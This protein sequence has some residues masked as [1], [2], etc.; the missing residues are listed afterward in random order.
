MEETNYLPGAEPLFLKGSKIGCLL[1]HGAGG[2][3]AW[4]L[5]EVAHYLHET[6]FKGELF[7]KTLQFINQ[8][9]T[10]S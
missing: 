3:T 6:E 9:I 4:D 7:D 1:L 10:T 8:V 2:G 5:K